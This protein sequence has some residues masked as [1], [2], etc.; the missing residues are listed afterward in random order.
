M[1]STL[2]L[3]FL[4][5]SLNTSDLVLSSVLSSVLFITICNQWLNSLLLSPSSSPI[6]FFS[7]VNLGTNVLLN[8]SSS[9]GEISFNLLIA[10]S[11]SFR[12]AFNFESSFCSLFDICSNV[13]RYISVI[14]R[15]ISVLFGYLKTI[16]FS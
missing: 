15:Y 6:P 3:Y 8:S 13:P 1:T 16:N 12:V 10:L 14:L 7:L 4:K 9:S 11:P 5:I 2:P